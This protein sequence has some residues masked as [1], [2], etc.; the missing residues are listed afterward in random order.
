MAATRQEIEGW[1]KRARMTGASHMLVVCDEFDWEDY[2]VSCTSEEQ[3][4]KRYEELH[5]KNM[6]RVMEVYKIDLGW[7]VQAGARVHNW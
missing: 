5:G 3:A 4:R 2:P 6:Q 7:E 1:F